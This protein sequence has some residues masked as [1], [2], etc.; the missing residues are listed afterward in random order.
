MKHFQTLKKNL[1]RNQRNLT[2][3]PN[4]PTKPIVLFTTK[5]DANT[6]SEKQSKQTVDRP[7]DRNFPCQTLKIRNVSLVIMH[8]VLDHHWK[9]P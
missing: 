5:T 2:N 3:T 4:L 9:N 7:N 1:F 8:T 6:T